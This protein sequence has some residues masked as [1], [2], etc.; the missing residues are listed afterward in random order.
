MGPWIIPFHSYSYYST[1]LTVLGCWAVRSV[2]AVLFIGDGCWEK[3][4]PVLLRTRYRSLLFDR[5]ALLPPTENALTTIHPFYTPAIRCDIPP[6]EDIYF[7]SAGISS[8]FASSF[9]TVVLFLLFVLVR[10]IIIV[11]GLAV[12]IWCL[13]RW[14]HYALVCHL[15]YCFDCPN[16]L[17]ERQQQQRLQQSVDHLLYSPGLLF[18]RHHHHHLRHGFACVSSRFIIDHHFE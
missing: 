12:S 14:S 6:R 11:A 9:S 8:S 1:D 13:T 15:L 7:C 17:H 10:I 18:C 5:T 3:M 2:W 16:V 4:M